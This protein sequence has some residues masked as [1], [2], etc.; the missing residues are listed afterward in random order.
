MNVF[1]RLFLVAALSGLVMTG[2]VA[3][4]QET[5]TA[6]PSGVKLVEASEVQTLQ[7]Q[8]AL[9]LDTRKA[10]EYAEGSIQGALSVPYDP[11]K[12]AKD[13]NFD[14]AQ[15]KFDLANFPDPTGQPLG[16]GEGYNDFA[17]WGVLV[18]TRDGLLAALA[19]ANADTTVFVDGDAVIDLTGM[20][21]IPLNP[22]VTLAS[23]RGSGGSLGALL[24]TTEMAAKPLFA[25]LGTGVRVTGLRLRGPDTNIAP[26]DC[27]GH[28][29]RAI[30]VED[31]NTLRNWV[32]RIDNNELW[33]WPGAAVEDRNVRGLRVD[34][35][36]IHH[37]RRQVRKTGCKSYG[38]GYGV[39]VSLG[40]ALIDGNIF[41]HNR[42]DIASDG[43][44]GSEYEARYNL[45]LNG[46]LQHSFDVHGGADRKDGTDIAG[47][48]F[49][50]HHNTFL[51]D[52]KP[53]FRIRGI[54]QT[55]AYVWQN[56][57]RHTSESDAANQV[58]A[59]GNFFLFDNRTSVRLAF[60]PSTALRC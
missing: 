39:V 47:T 52:S 19:S 35:N 3:L 44:P 51:Q 1:N 14:P 53:A 36:H 34:H 46:P 49:R 32:V 57:F 54:P 27:G 30:G 28:D 7:A 6:P 5:P 17:P 21:E 41:D 16:G 12:S 10:A 23:S 15:D 48:L 58:N 38:L 50:V 37:N 22:G 9:I 13:V 33:G 18:S 11:E 42:H 29:T 31:Y 55:G 25:V 45:V 26:A 40:Q 56:E 8:G 20:L 2:K 43:S 4:A 60:R 59:G 24:Y